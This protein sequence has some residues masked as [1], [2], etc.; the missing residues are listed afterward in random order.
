MFIWIGISTEISIGRFFS[1]VLGI[2]SDR[3][4]GISPSLELILWS[5]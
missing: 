2:K 5:H 1:S 4:I 3:E